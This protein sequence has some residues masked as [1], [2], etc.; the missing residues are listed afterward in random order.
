ME[1]YSKINLRLSL[2]KTYNLFAV[3]EGTPNTTC[4]EEGRSPLMVG[5]MRSS[6]S[7]LPMMALNSSIVGHSS[8]PFK[9]KTCQEGTQKLAAT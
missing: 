1:K 8:I 4:S 7:G 5:K 2:P 9:R 3:V 6:I